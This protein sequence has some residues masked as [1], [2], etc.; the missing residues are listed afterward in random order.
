MNVLAAG[1]M[2]LLSA[3]TGAGGVATIVGTDG[4]GNK[5]IYQSKASQKAIPPYVLI[6]EP[7]D[8]PQYAFGNSNQADHVFYLVQGF[9]ADSPTASGPA[10]AGTLADRIRAL[11]LNPSLTV[12][13]KT[14]V[15]CAP[16]Q[17]TTPLEE[18][19]D[20]NSRWIYSRGWLI[21]IWVA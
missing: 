3:D 20:T 9:A 17:T 2:T 21:D 6:R 4:D 12:S 1:L 8:F 13:G 14:V 15:S 19:D 16:L 10:T 5:Q 11:C 7:S 18:W